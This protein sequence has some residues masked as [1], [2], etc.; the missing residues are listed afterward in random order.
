MRTPAQGG[1]C[2]SVRATLGDAMWWAAW[3]LRLSENIK[4]AHGNEEC[5]AGMRYPGRLPV[6]RTPAR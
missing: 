4:V 3:A 5:A 6:A 2:A 1:C